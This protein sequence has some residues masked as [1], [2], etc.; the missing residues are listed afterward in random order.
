[1]KNVLIV[2]SLFLVSILTYGQSEIY[3]KVKIHLQT[4][5]LQQIGQLGIAIEGKVEKGKFLTGEFSEQELLKLKNTG[6]YYDVLVEDVKKMYVERNKLQQTK[7]S[8]PAGKYVTPTHFRLGSLGGYLTLNELMAELDSMHLHYPNLVTARQTID[9][10]ETYE[11]RNIYYVKIS[12]NPNLNENEPEIMYASLTH[13]RE[14]MGMQQLIYYMWY[15]LENYDTDAEIRYLV[16]NCQMYFAPC[17][18][19]DGYRYNQQ[20]D[21]NG[22]G[23]WRKNR[24]NV[25]NTDYGI[26]L[27]RNYGYQWG[28]DNIGSSPSPSS[29]T[30]R[31]SAPFSEP[32]TLA[33]KWFAENHN[34]QLILDYHTYSDVLLYPW[35]YMDQVCEDSILYSTYSA[36]LT[37]TNGFAYGTANQC[38]GYNANGGSFD[39]FYGEQ[40]T[41]NKIIAWGPEVGN[42]D[43]GFWPAMDRIE[44]IAQ[45]YMDQN[46]W[47]ARLALDYAVIQNNGENY[48][49]EKTGY[50]KFQ[51]QKIGMQ[52]DAGY[53][54]S[55]AGISAN[56]TSTGEPVRIE[57]VELLSFKTDSIAYSLV[58]QMDFG[59][60]IQFLLTI[61]N[62]KLVQYDTITKIFG[63]PVYVVLDSCNSLENWSGHSW[64]ISGTE[65]HS[66]FSSVCDSPEGEYSSNTNSNII[67][68][69]EVEIPVGIMAELTYYAKWDLEND[70]DYVQFFVSS[71]NGATWNWLESEHMNTASSH[72]PQGQAL[73]DGTQN[74]WVKESF[75][76]TPYMGQN[77]KFKFTLVSDGSIEG[78]GFYFDDFTIKTLEYNPYNHIETIQPVNF[79]LSPNPAVGFLIIRIQKDSENQNCTLEIFNSLGQKCSPTFVLKEESQ[80]PV[81]NLS[82]GIYFIKLR[83]KDGIITRKFIKK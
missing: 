50:L 22:G 5:T 51:L 73:Y 35:G 17:V 43:D 75:D 63:T 29:M 66:S 12:D 65:Y 60:T 30:Y 11:G 55:L 7:T 82:K 54:I 64:G 31:G 1:M 76:L 53:T 37:E 32:E 57:N 70:Y 34:I 36:I 3:K 83:Y 23:M 19:P 13:A 45:I 67:L 9:S 6:I 39:W 46:L 41:K 26:D 42:P 52:Q 80:I 33:M 14:P 58:N 74:S 25:N 24:R 38:I 62:G 40:E 68:A 71:N 56:V 28:Y 49:G 21:P 72:Q 61:D 16:D 2:C 69:Q 78:D 44:T 81:S 15:L 27:N 18:N 8:E 20:T 59:D 47:L 79:S 4:N 10:F 77:L 48:L